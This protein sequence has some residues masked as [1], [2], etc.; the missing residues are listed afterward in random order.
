[1][2]AAN[3]SGGSQHSTNFSAGRVLELS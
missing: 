2:P 1:V 3:L